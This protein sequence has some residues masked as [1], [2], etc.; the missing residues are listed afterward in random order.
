[1]LRNIVEL[2]PYQGKVFVKEGVVMRL[3]GSSCGGSLSIVVTREEVGVF[4]AV[5]EG[6]N[7]TWIDDGPHVDKLFPEE[8]LNGSVFPSHQPLFELQ[9]PTKE[10]LVELG[11]EGFVLED[12]T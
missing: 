3:E 9:S 1:M 2:M 7:T 8:G 11:F 12:A 4:K 5:I 6:A 10:Q